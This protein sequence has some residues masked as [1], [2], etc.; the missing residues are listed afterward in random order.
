MQLGQ[1]GLSGSQGWPLGLDREGSRGT[2][3]GRKATRAVSDAASEGAIAF[4]SRQP[5]DDDGEDVWVVSS[6]P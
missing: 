1:R 2:G 3:S 4:R 6:R 5:C